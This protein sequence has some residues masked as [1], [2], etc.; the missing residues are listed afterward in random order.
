MGKKDEEAGVFTPQP[1]PSR[2]AIAL[3]HQ[4]TLCPEAQIPCVIGE[5]LQKEQKISMFRGL[6][7]EFSI[8]DK[9]QRIRHCQHGT[10]DFPEK[11]YLTRLKEEQDLAYGGQGNPSQRV[12]NKG[13]EAGI[14]G[15]ERNPAKL[16]SGVVGLEES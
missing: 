1:R 7:F 13:T 16:G 10:K 5:T 6:S 9:G 3:Q 8:L 14:E 15:L 2:P 12:V 4:L 11:Q